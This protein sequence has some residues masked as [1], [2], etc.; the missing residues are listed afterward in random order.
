M[1]ARRI[2]QILRGNFISK[3]DLYLLNPEIAARYIPKHAQ[4]MAIPVCPGPLRFVHTTWKEQMFGPLGPSL[5]PYVRSSRTL[6][7]WF[8]PVATWYAGLAGYRRVGLVYDDLRTSHD[9]TIKLR[10]LLVL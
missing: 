10:A 7:K 8:K 1:D 3:S 9:P 4:T 2:A 6:S 5:A